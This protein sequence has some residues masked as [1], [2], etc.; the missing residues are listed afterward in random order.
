MRWPPARVAGFIR[1]AGWPEDQLATATAVALASSQGDDHFTW[2]V[3]DP[4]VIDERGLFAIDDVVDE[5]PADVDLFDPV[6]NARFALLLWRRTGGDWSWNSAYRSGA[7]RELGDVASAAVVTSRGSGVT[8]PSAGNVATASR[9]EVM[10]SAGER[11]VKA[12][13]GLANAVTS[14]RP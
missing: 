13:V 10:R 9:V 4:P 7:Y 8:P 6:A 1:D 2:V 14:L 5:V 3:G 12:L 11:A